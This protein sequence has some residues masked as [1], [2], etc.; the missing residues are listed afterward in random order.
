MIQI[1]CDKRCQLKFVSCRLHPHLKMCSNSNSLPKQNNPPCWI[2]WIDF[3]KTFAK[4]PSELT[5]K[6]RP[7]SSGLPTQTDCTTFTR[8]SSRFSTFW[9]RIFRG[10][11]C[12]FY[13][14]DRC[15]ERTFAV[16]CDINLNATGLQPVYYWTF[17]LLFRLRLA[18][19]IMSSFKILQQRT[20]IRVHKI[21]SKWRSYKKTLTWTSHLG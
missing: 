17:W 9:H 21:L 19:R 11:K 1:G 3:L 18:A 15:C 12:R 4:L 7:S 20:S 13:E 16:F 8:V 14:S 2:S 6:K 5:M 10:K